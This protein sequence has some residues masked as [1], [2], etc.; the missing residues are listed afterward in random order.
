VRQHYRQRGLYHEQCAVEIDAHHLIEIGGL[1]LCHRRRPQ[2][3]G[4]VHQH[5]DAPPGAFDARHRGACRAHVADVRADHA[6]LATGAAHRIGDAFQHGAAPR[7]QRHLGAEPR[8]QQ[9]RLA[10]DAARRAGDHDDLAVEGAE[11]WAQCLR[12][13][14]GCVSGVGTVAE[15]FVPRSALC[16]PRSPQPPPRAQRGTVNAERGTSHIAPLHGLR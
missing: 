7:H 13:H 14:A 4:V 1:D 12:K 10:P 2:H 15:W 9:G 11:R 8:E 3:A 5:V 16:V 6:R